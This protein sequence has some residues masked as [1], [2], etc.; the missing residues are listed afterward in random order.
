MAAQRIFFENHLPQ[1]ISR[2]KIRRIWGSIFRLKTST[3]LQNHIGKLT[4]LLWNVKIFPLR[5]HSFL[6]YIL[7]MRFSLMDL[8]IYRTSQIA[9]YW[10][11]RGRE[12][13]YQF[14]IPLD[15]CLSTVCVMVFGTECYHKAS[16]L[17]IDIFLKKYQNEKTVPNPFF[18]T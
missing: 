7:A 1:K 12:T 4:F 15:R 3:T 10:F 17:C 6:L 18:R 13:I 5:G 8:V 16:S 11:A 2:Y 9:S 14:R